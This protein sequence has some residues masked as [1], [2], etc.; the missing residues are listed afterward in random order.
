MTYFLHN[1]CFFKCMFT[2][3]LGSPQR[4]D[5]YTEM[6][7][8]LSGMSVEIC[9]RGFP[10]AY[11]YVFMLIIMQKKKRSM[12]LFVVDKCIVF[13]GRWRDHQLTG[14]NFPFRFDDPDGGLENEEFLPSTDGKKPIRFTD[15]S[16][17][18]HIYRHKAAERA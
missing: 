11:V 18:A 2:L 8:K 4:V 13:R 14:I 10:T 15:V 7:L 16:V 5:P 6:A 9:V 12:L 3:F 17:K 1:L